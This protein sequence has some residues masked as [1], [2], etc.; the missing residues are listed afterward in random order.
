MY[1]MVRQN[2]VSLTKT[3]LLW[4]FGDG[5]T[6][7]LPRIPRYMNF[8]LVLPSN[9]IIVPCHRTQGYILYGTEWHLY[10]TSNSATIH[11]AFFVSTSVLSKTTTKTS[12]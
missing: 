12:Q 9:T 1:L 11:G 10:G 8:R 6:M 7:V 4:Y 3:E 2:M 5:F